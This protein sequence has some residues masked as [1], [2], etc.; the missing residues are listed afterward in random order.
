MKIVPG[1]EVGV[2]NWGPRVRGFR[3]GKSNGRSRS[4]GR[5]WGGIGEVGAC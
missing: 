5:G 1:K 4:K 3:P 2:G